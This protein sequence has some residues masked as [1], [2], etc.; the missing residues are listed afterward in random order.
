MKHIK[1]IYVIIGLKL[2]LSLIICLFYLFIDDKQS[3]IKVPQYILILILAYT[4][5]QYFSWQ[6][7]PKQSLIRYKRFYYIGLLAICLPIFL[8]SDKYAIYWIITVK[9][10][11]WML[12]ISVLME[13]RWLAK[14]N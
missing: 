4:T 5:I 10:F 7:Y 14:H 1:Y 13:I 12:L 3:I 2:I 8:Y 11:C 6:L 9:S